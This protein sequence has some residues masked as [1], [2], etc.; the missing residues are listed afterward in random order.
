MV[1]WDNCCHGASTGGPCGIGLTY[2]WGLGRF[3]ARHWL[4][5]DGLRGSPFGV[6]GLEG[7]RSE[8]AWIISMH[9]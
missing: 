9:R 8:D 2:A 3:V 1:G 5:D 4:V 7:R 6:V